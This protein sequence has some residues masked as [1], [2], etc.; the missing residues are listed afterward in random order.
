V[1]RIGEGTDKERVVT[2]WWTALSYAEGST[3][4]QWAQP[5]HDLVSAGAAGCGPSAA[6]E[7]RG[8]VPVPVSHVFPPQGLPEGILALG[9]TGEDDPSWM[10]AAQQFDGLRAQSLAAAAPEGDF[11]E[12]DFESVCRSGIP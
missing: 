10:L 8:I 4:P 12:V 9:R 6:Q 1:F 3:C 7:Q 2:Q 5:V 11:D